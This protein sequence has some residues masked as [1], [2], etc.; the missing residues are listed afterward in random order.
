MAQENAVATTQQRH[1]ALQEMSKVLPTLRHLLPEDLPIEKFRAAI[2]LEFKERPAL[3]ECIPDTVMTCA[4][5]AATHGLMPSRDCHFLPFK[6][7]RRGGKKVA[8][9]VPNYQGIQRALDRTG[10]IK[11]SFAHPVYSRDHYEID[12]LADI[13]SHRP[14]RGD[15]GSVICY[16]GCVM[17]KDGTV[18][19]QEMSIEEIDAIKKRSP[20]HETGPWLTDYVAMARKTVLKQV[21]K[22][23]NLTEQMNKL[24]VEDEDRERDDI[25]NERIAQHSADLFGDDDQGVAFEVAARGGNGAT[26]EVRDVTPLDDDASGEE[27]VDTVTGE[28]V[29]GATVDYDALIDQVDAKRKE[30]GLTPPKLHN[31]VRA[32]FPDVAGVHSCKPAQLH[33]IL[34]HLTRHG[35][36]ALTRDFDAGDAT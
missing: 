10:K 1:P 5:K 11:K 31:W 36:D 27:H 25:P 21:A 6:D 24:I 29:D 3:Y 28:I 16:Y 4:I 12:Y 8:T 33:Q 26:A 14:A 32:Q 2:W 9:L 35:A 15:R 30:Y 34:A 23:C 18:H 19:V 13:F 17:M 7:K 20:A 22:Y